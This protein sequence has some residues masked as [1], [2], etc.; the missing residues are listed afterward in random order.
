M[1]GSFSLAEKL[2]V[3]GAFCALVVLA[4]GTEDDPGIVAAG[5]FAPR[6]TAAKGHP[7]E[8]ERSG[9]NDWW[10]SDGA[11]DEPDAAPQLAPESEDELPPGFGSTPSPEELT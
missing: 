2:A 6:Q 8:P 9:A 1:G 11:P 3:A 5:K 10:Q 4:V 7:D